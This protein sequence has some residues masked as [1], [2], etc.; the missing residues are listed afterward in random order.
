MCSSDLVVVRSRVDGQLMRVLFLTLYPESAA[1]PRYRVH[2]FLPYL[3]EHGTTCDVSCPFTEADYARLRAKA[4]AGRARGR[5]SMRLKCFVVN[6]LTLTTLARGQL[7]DVSTEWPTQSEEQ[8]SF[9]SN[10]EALKAALQS[11]M[12]PVY[13]AAGL[14]ADSQVLARSAGELRLVVPSPPPPGSAPPPGSKQ[15][16][17]SGTL[18]IVGL[19]IG[20]LQAATSVNESSV[21]FIPKLLVL[22]AVILLVGPSSLGVFVDYLRTVIVDIPEIHKAEAEE[23]RAELLEMAS[24]AND[25]LA[26]TLLEE[27]PVSEELLKKALREGT[28]KGLFTPVVCGSSKNFHGVQQLLDHVIEIGRAHV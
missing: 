12:G 26:E 16:A 21:A 17:D 18:L 28:L 3:R 6:L 11:Q 5:L 1:S 14:P 19:V 25:E 9:G 27:K 13:S 4:A 20:I 8:I 15:A 2:Q 23:K 24:L 22:G 10:A 7:L